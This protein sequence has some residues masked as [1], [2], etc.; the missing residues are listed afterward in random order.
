MH[1]HLSTNPQTDMS[2]VLS[3][4]EMLH[5]DIEAM[6]SIIAGGDFAAPQASVNAPTDSA[7]LAAIQELSAQLRTP[8]LRYVF[9]VGIGGSN[10]GTK[11]IY[12]ALYGYADMTATDRPHVIFLDTNND[13]QLRHCFESIVPTLTSSEEYVVVTVSKS[14]GTTE[15][16]MNTELLVAALKEHGHYDATRMVAITDADSALDEAAAAV[17]WHRLHI[18]SQVGGRYSAFTAVGLFPCALIGVDIERLLHGAVA[19]RDACARPEVAHNPAAQ[20][21]AYLALAYEAGHTICDSFIF[22]AELESLG[23]WYRQLMGESIGKEKN[24]RGELVRTGL[25]PTVSIGSTDLHSVGQLYLGGPKDKV[26]TFMYSTDTSAAQS[27]PAERMLPD[28]VTMITGKQ[29]A[30][31]RAAIIAGTQRAYQA[32]QLPYMEVELERIDAYELGAF[33]QYKMMEMMYLGALLEV[34]PFDQPNV[35]A[36]KTETKR[37]LEAT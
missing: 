30:E 20:S 35:E 29:S 22:H 12:D 10:L 2:A 6:G 37:L 5:S 31:V 25:T 15:T 21:A 36:Y 28:V 26:T 33:M 11:A 1:V 3:R 8:Q 4:A 16:I 27:M 19:M 14:G 18:P 7:S 9:V 17:G 32:N 24:T 23:K 13:A 34:N